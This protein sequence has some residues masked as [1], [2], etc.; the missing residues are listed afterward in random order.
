MA[1]NYLVSLNFSYFFKDFIMNYRK[2]I[3]EG[4]SQMSERPI[5]G[6]K[7][8]FVQ[9]DAVNDRR[10]VE[11]NG[12]AKRVVYNVKVSDNGTGKFFVDGN[13]YSEFRSLLARFFLFFIYRLFFLEKFY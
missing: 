2:L 7:I 4:T 9:I 10:F 8:P 6:C 1:M 13:H 12:K 5:F 11:V 3:T